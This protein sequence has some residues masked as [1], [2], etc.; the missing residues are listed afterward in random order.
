MSDKGVF[1]FADDGLKFFSTAEDAAADMEW[2]DVE[3]AAFTKPSSLWV[4]S[5]WCLTP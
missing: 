3:A 2:V 5:A 4:A 1:M